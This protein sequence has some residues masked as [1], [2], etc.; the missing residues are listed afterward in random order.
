MTKTL[1]VVFA[2]SIFFVLGFVL[3]MR[4]L[5]RE[6]REIDK[7]IDYRKVNVLSDDEEDS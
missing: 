3:S 2:V 4:S 1:W 6:N 7:K 5:L